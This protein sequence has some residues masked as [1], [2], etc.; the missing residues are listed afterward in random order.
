MRGRG[1]CDRSLARGLHPSGLW[2]GAVDIELNTNQ[3]AHNV[4]VLRNTFD[5]FNLFAVA[6]THSGTTGDVDGVEIAGN[7]TLSTGDTC[8]PPVL[9]G[10]HPFDP[11]LIL[12]VVVRDNQL[13]TLG[14]GISLDHV[15][16]GSVTQPHRED[17][18]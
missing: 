10:D 1:G 17:R 11:N 8:R 16:I 3:R 4:K 15:N 7:R 2:Y 14:N 13:K 9:V 5:G 18:G 6:A 12:R